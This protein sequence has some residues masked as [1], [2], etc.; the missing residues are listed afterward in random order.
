[1]AQEPKTFDN[2]PMDCPLW[3]RHFATILNA[4][5]AALA[6]AIGGNIGGES[7]IATML[8]VYVAVYVAWGWRINHKQ[9]F[10][11]VE[12]FG[13]L[14]RIC[15]GG[16]PILCLPGLIDRVVEDEWSTLEYQHFNLYVDQ[17]KK[18]DRE[19]ALVNFTDGSAVVA[20]TLNFCIGSPRRDNESEGEWRSRLKN[21]IICWTYAYE[22]PVKRIEALADAYVRP[23]LGTRTI[24][25]ATADMGDIGNKAA[26]EIE[27]LLEIFG[28]YLAEKNSV[29]IRNIEIPEELQKIR[30]ERLMGEASGDETAMALDRLSKIEQLKGMSPE[31]LRDYYLRIEL[32]R[33]L[34]KTGNVNFVAPNMAG[35]MAVV[36]VGRK[37]ANSN[38]PQPPQGGP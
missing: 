35:V 19:R 23:E 5:V 9:Q 1:M 21:A 11:V 28:A 24:D 33:N 37:P 4:L 16:A 17:Y 18:L 12:R 22:E 32:V 13:Y 31:D 34:G 2:I 29:L 7:A 27:S 15:I 36:D 38:L 30:M 25:K 6:V 10:F 14:L 8:I 26:K 20:I 3:V